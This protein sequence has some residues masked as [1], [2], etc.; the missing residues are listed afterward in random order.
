MSILGSL[1]SGIIPLIIQIILSIL[2]GGLF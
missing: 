1:F 2:T